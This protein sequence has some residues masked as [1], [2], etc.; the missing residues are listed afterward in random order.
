MNKSVGLLV[1]IRDPKLVEKSLKKLKRRISK[2]FKIDYGEVHHWHKKEVGKSNGE[3]SHIAILFDSSKRSYRAKARISEVLDVMGDEVWIE[4]KSGR[5]KKGIHVM[6]TQQDI[7]DF[8]YHT[9]YLAKVKT[10]KNNKPSFS[11]SRGI[12]THLK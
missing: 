8:I 10:A 2:A 9:S 7:E 4:H 1:V 6:T 12:K 3:H 5:G 11:K